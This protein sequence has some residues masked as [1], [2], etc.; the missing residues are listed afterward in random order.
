MR[1]IL[2]SCLLLT[3]GAGDAPPRL[4][5]VTWNVLHEGKPAALSESMDL[6]G[7][8]SFTSRVARRKSYCTPPPSDSLAAQQ[9]IWT[10][11]ISR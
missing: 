11:Q 1:L 7:G 9:A 5:L 8:W 10:S 2:A 3:A 4:T 6:M